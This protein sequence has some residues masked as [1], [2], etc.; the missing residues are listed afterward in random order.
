[1]RTDEDF[2]A[3]AAIF[4]VGMALP[5]AVALAIHDVLALYLTG[6][7]FASLGA[8]AFALLTWVLLEARE[9]DRANF[10]VASLVLPWIG[11]VGVVFVG[12]TVGQHPG[13][14]RYLFG[15]FEDLGAYAALYTIG[16]VVAVALLRGVER[17]TRRDGWRPAPLT[18]AVGLVAV[19]VLGSAVGGAYVTIAASSASISDVEADV[20]DRRSS[21][22]TDGTG[23][24][25][26]VEG[27][28]TELRLTV[29]APDGTTAVERLTDE[30]LRDG[31]ATVEL[32]DWRFDAPLRAGTYEVE[33][34][35]LT[36]V[37]VDR[38][39]YTIE[40]EPTPS[41]RQ[42]E[43]VPPNGEPTI[44]VPTDATGRESGTESQ[45]RIVTVI[46]NEGDAPSEFATRLVAGDGEFV[47]VEA[48]VIEPG[49]SG[50]T[51][52]GLSD[53]DVERVHRESDGELEVEVIFDGEVVT[54]ERVMLPAPETD[55][56]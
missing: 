6:R 30:D 23:L 9:I 26:V 21:Y 29:T 56:G 41:L 47:T 51:V 25:V 24:V 48:I 32:E 43:V 13:G 42:V 35:A 20:I 17:F 54:T 45:V 36:G 1:M 10:L 38:T 22:E 37:T 27:E 40:T 8:A 14:F 19:L 2:P 52:V 11:A 34:S 49:R 44:D 15:E 39:T 46:A 28:P 16:G 55:S 50:V 3:V 18:V 7:Q 53:E 33:L 12:F 31:T 4:V 5:I